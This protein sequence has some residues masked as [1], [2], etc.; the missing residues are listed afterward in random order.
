MTADE[1]IQLLDLKPHPEGGFYREAFK[2]QA[3]IPGLKP[4]RFCSTAIYYMLAA[5][6][7]SKIHRLASDEIF[8]F[9]MGDPVTWVL[10]KPNG[11]IEKTVLGSGLS[12]GQTPQMAVQAGTWFGGYLND[13][14][15]FALMGTTMAPGFEFEDFALGDRKE[16]IARFP[17]AEA[18][19]ARLT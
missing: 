11:K 15:K 1:I 16:L 12:Q 5:G 7:V 4:P 14:G 9:Y 6:T 8:H 3:L 2:S 17:Q 18:D 10:L 13:G 19:I